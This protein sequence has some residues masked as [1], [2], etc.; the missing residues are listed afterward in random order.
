MSRYILISLV[1]LAAD[2][3]SLVQSSL[4][5]NIAGVHQIA[6]DVH[7][8]PVPTARHGNSIWNNMAIFRDRWWAGPVTDYIN[9]DWGILQDQGNG[10]P[11]EIIDGFTFTY[12]T[13]NREM[14]GESLS[15]HFYDSCTG[16]GNMGILEA[17]FTFTGLPNAATYGTLPPGYGWAF[18]VSVDLEGSGYEF[19]LGEEIGIGYI[20]RTTPQ[21]GGTGFCVGCPGNKGGN[22]YTGTE[23][24]WDEYYPNGVYLNTWYFGCGYPTDPW[25]TFSTELFGG[26]DPATTMA[27]EGI[28]AQGN[29]AS[30][31][32]VG[33]WAPGS[34]VQFLMRKND[35][36][37]PGWLIASTGLSQKYYPGLDVTLLPGFPLLAQMPMRPDAVGDFDRYGLDVGPVL[38]GLRLYFQG[39]LTA[40][41]PLGPIDLSNGVYSN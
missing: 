27:Y 17:G 39:A 41:Q 23:D 25:M 13:N 3:D 32:V 29:D 7:N 28:G 12:A 15:I 40:V 22:G 37:L 8:N 14:T 9:L 10:L 6:R 16:N 35:L 34:R 4:S 26:Q 30:L 19:L 18:S 1:F 36:Q 5:N 38:S 33:D 2:A 31:Y 21:M 11:D 24:R 20:R